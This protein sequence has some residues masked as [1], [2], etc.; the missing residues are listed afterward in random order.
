MLYDGELNADLASQR[1]SRALIVHA[2]DCDAQ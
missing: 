1:L 2:R